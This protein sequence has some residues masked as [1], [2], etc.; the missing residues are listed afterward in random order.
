MPGL[1]NNRIC[2]VLI[3]KQ[4]QDSNFCSITV[5]YIS[6]LSSMILWSRT[7]CQEHLFY[8]ELWTRIIQ[9][10]NHVEYCHSCTVMG[11]W[12][13][14]L[15][16]HKLESVAICLSLPGSDLIRIMGCLTQEL[17]EHTCILSKHQEIWHVSIR[18]SS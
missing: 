16:L 18:K 6:I 14:L 15:I 2:G 5:Q 17:N 4:I 12:P 8:Q 11:Y 9:I 3:D 10:V 7:P 13:N 1:S